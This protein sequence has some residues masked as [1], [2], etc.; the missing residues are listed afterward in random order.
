MP[1]QPKPTYTHI[2]TCT[3]TCN[4]CGHQYQTKYYKIIYPQGHKQALGTDT[5][6]YGEEYDPE[7]EIEHRKH[8][9][10]HG[11]TL[12]KEYSY[13]GPAHYNRTKTTHNQPH[14]A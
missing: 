13:L 7:A 6:A 5:T 12:D 2:G 4:H 11:G 10:T 8:L 1:K 3:Y 9:T 14:M